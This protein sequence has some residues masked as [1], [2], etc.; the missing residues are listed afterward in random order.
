MVTGNFFGRGCRCL[1]TLNNRRLSQLLRFLYFTTD[2]RRDG[3]LI[4]EVLVLGTL[5]VDVQRFLE[6]L[7]SLIIL[8]VLLLFQVVAGWGVHAHLR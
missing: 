6:T 5:F 3:V 8:H 7:V 2:L 1:V 4:P